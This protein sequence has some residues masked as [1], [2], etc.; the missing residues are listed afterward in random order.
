[1]RNTQ[2]L[3][4]KARFELARVAPLPPQDSVS[5]ISPLRLRRGVYKGLFFDV[6][7]VFVIPV[8][9]SPCELL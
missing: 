2:K 6:Q 7:V 9:T 4:P 1:M 8:K 3:V 5:T